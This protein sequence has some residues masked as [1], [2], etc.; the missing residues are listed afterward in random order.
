[1]PVRYEYCGFKAQ[2]PNLENV[3]N[4]KAKEYWRLKLIERFGASN[5]EAEWLVLME[6]QK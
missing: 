6:R 4:E 5:F 1:M 3:L 2:W